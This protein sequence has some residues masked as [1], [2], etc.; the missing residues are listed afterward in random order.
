MDWLPTSTTRHDVAPSSPAIGQTSYFVDSSELPPRRRDR[1]AL[2]DLLRTVALIRIILWHLSAQTW[3]TWIAALPVMFFVLGTVTQPAPSGHLSFVLGTVTR[4]GPSGHLS[5]VQRRG[6]RLLVPF[7]FY[8]VTIG[9]L[10]TLYAVANTAKVD[11]SLAR[12]V[13]WVLP[14]VDPTATSWSGGWLSSHLWYLRAVLW[15]TL[16]TPILRVAARHLRVSAAAVVIG[17]ASLSAAS[18]SGVPYLGRGQ[19][20]LLSG[21][22]VVY[23]FFTVLGIA[24]GNRK[25]TGSLRRRTLIAIFGW[26]GALLFAGIAGVPA[27]GVN[28]SYPLIALLGIATLASLSLVEEPLRTLAGHRCVAAATRRVSSRA[29]TIYLWHPLCIVGAAHLVPSTT[30]PLRS[31]GLAVVTF[32][33]IGASA[34][35]FGWIEDLA[36]S[37]RRKRIGRSA[38]SRRMGIAA[39]LTVFAAGSFTPGSWVSAAAVRTLNSG[40]LVPDIPAPSSRAALRD[41]AFTTTATPPTT[42]TLL[43]L[44]TSAAAPLSFDPPWSAPSAIA[45]SAS[46]DSPVLRLGSASPAVA[47]ATTTVPSPA[48]R[49]RA[50]TTMP[51]RRGAPTTTLS[52]ATAIPKAAPLTTTSIATAARTSGKTVTTGAPAMPTTTAP[53]PAEKLQ[54]AFDAWR[55]QVEPAIS[56]SVVAIRIG[57]YTWTSRSADSGVDSKYRTTR[58][59]R[60]SSIT[61][62]FTAALVLRA[63][64]SGDLRLDDQVASLTGVSEPA[65]TGLTVRQLLTHTSGLVDYRAAP[66][67]DPSAPLTVADAVALSLRAP[68]VGAGSQVSYANSNYLY[69]G[70]LL[71]QTTGKSYAHLVRELTTEVGLAETRLDETPQ[72]GWVGFSSGG[73]MS[74]TSDLAKWGQAL[75]TPGKVL[76]ERALARMTTIGDSN[77]GLGAWPACPCSTDAQ[78]VKRYTAIGHH[79]ADG[80]VFYFPA[81]G[82]TVVAMFE[83]TGHDTHARIVSLAAALTT[84]LA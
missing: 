25:A 26:I 47:T 38:L 18:A 12:V 6:R 82:M 31:I 35:A 10:S 32:S 33:L 40:T 69:L 77:V 21:D 81:T 63:A 60:A 45:S 64:D 3:L 57:A 41:A 65:P 59:F 74:T 14:V 68:M 55:V 78:G 76:S 2:L 67:Y 44:R 9:S 29:L 72:P 79:T 51:A 80:G 4:P 73:I 30:G 13:A 75:F 20:H 19:I 54:R 23:G 22:L 50:V 58:E 66:G 27:G 24:Y 49:T 61:K 28:S 46:S 34:V 52:P 39:I 71:E 84:A 8:G 37:A 11:I 5:F 56:S 70:L 1:D 15:I 62:T 48:T 43:A 83:S 42:P 17:I 16:L 7:W 36:G 53:L